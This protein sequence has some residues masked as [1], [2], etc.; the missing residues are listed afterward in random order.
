MTTEL[1][2]QSERLAIGRTDKLQHP[3]HSVRDIGLAAVPHQGFICRR[4]EF[5]AGG[6]QISLCRPYRL[7]G[8][9]YD[10]LN[11]RVANAALK[12]CLAPDPNHVGTFVIMCAG[13]QDVT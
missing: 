6:S 5:S 2:H 7:N 10:K 8:L 9:P 12:W 13:D 1:G 3:Q 11:V 4:A